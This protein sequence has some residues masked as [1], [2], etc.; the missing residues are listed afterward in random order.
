VDS[1]R[2]EHLIALKCSAEEKARK[3]ESRNSQQWWKLALAY[4]EMATEEMK[5]AAGK[6]R[7]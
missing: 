6:P 4:A 7:P 5:K 3:G 1:A 2:F